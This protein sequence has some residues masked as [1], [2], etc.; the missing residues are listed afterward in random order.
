M[1]RH[2]AHKRASA[3]KLVR[4][5]RAFPFN[6]AHMIG[7]LK[8][9]LGGV[10]T[11]LPPLQL[12]SPLAPPGYTSPGAGAPPGTA[13]HAAVQ[14]FHGAA[15]PVADAEPLWPPGPDAAPAQDPHPV[16]E[17]RASAAP[18]LAELPPD[19]AAAWRG[20]TAADG[21]PL[22]PRL[23]AL[24][25][26]QLRDRLARPGPDEGRGWIAS[27]LVHLLVAGYTLRNDPTDLEKAV[28]TGDELLADLPRSSPHYIDLLTAVESYRHMYGVLC[29]HSASVERAASALLWARTRLTEGTLPWLGVSIPY[30]HALSDLSGLLRD[31][32]RS[33]EA[34]RVMRDVSRCLD[35]LPEQAAPHGAEPLLDRLRPAFDQVHRT[36]LGTDA[37]V[38]GDSDAF[39][40]AEAEWDPAAERSLPPMARFENAR[41][42]VGRAIESRQWD[43]AADAASAAL[44]M[45]P[46]LTSRALARDDRQEAL[47]TALLG[48]R[49]LM[50]APHQGSVGLPD[51]ITGTS[52]GRTGCAAAIAA[53]RTGQALTLLEQGRAVL[54]AQDLEARTDVSD[55]AAVLP[56]AAARFTALSER[57]L[58]TEVEG[59]GGGD[60]SARV[61]ERHALAEE[62]RL[63]L[64]EIRRHPQGERFLLP[65]T[66]Q[67]L[68][69]DAAHGPIV[70]LNV[71]PL[72][73][74]ALVATP[75]GVRHVPLQVTEGNLADR[76]QEFLTAVALDRDSPHEQQE[77]RE[78]IFA[79]LEWLWDTVAEPVLD[80]AGLTAPLPQHPPRHAIPRLCV[81]RVRPAGPSAPARRRIPAQEPARGTPVG[82]GPG[83]L[84]LHPQHQGA[85]P[86]PPGRG[87][88]EGARLLPRHRAADRGPRRPRSVRQ[89]SGRGR[90]GAD[91][92]SHPGRPRRDPGPGA[93]RTARGRPGALRLPRCQRRGEPR[94]EPSVAWGRPP[95]RRRDLPAAAAARAA[96]PAAGLPHRPHGPDARRGDPPG[97]GVPRSRLPPGGRRPV[98]SPRPG[99]GPADRPVLPLHPQLRLR[100]RRTPREPRPAHDRPRTARPLR[101]ISGGVGAVRAHGLLNTEHQGR[102]TA[103]R[104]PPDSS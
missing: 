69:D 19:A 92:P 87:A 35:A 60:E 99:V 52:L 101:Q 36:V 68:C 97:L 10:L 16:A 23:L 18:P 62:W 20:I 40:T 72:R 91:E 76:A 67:Q 65:S 4:L 53:G 54:M 43:Q 85:A 96:G 42:A 48:R 100:C 28:R 5:M 49:Y 25:E 33:A 41:L 98:G 47:R 3:A 66:E 13:G 77:A 24:A 90:T 104:W 22:D 64:A 93:R 58:R 8:P 71:D 95:H 103:H 7:D 39:D 57:T 59:E 34:V 38:R 21:T 55:L 89:R 86:R 51:Q 32:V 1:L 88:R 74:D 15:A 46:L 73:C 31:P 81:V 61:R 45:L 78:V 11:E 9:L 17:P 50:A 63:L 83:R 102:L 75:H 12:D 14:D 26:K 56:Q 2:I 70:M 29:R 79:T 84:L 30:A 6:A 94:R 82:P 37:Y 80:A 44:E 27:V